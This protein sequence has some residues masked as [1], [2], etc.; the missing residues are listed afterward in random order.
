MQWVV[1][2]FI[3]IVAADVFTGNVLVVAIMLINHSGAINPRVTVTDR[4]ATPLAFAFGSNVSVPAGGSLLWEA[5]D[6]KGWF[7]SGGLRWACDTPSAV[8]GRIAYFTTA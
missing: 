7:A 3:P 2:Q 5:P 8:V 4:Q 6:F 1:G